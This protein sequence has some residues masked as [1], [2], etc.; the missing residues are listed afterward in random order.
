M[1]FVG[2]AEFEIERKRARERMEKELR[3]REAR[4]RREIA[5]T[6]QLMRREKEMEVEGDF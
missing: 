6:I 1:L 4:E 3:E 5:Q 2:G